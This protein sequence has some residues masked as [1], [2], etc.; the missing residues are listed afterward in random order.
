MAGIRALDVF[1]RKDRE[2]R[3]RQAVRLAQ[4]REVEAQ[5]QRRIETAALAQALADILTQLRVGSEQATFERRRQLL[6][7]LLDRGVVTDEELKM[8]HAIPTTDARTHSRFCQLRTDDLQIEPA[9][10]GPPAQGGD[11]AEGAAAPERERLG[12]T[13]LPG[14]AAYFDQDERALDDRSRLPVP[15][16]GVGL[17]L[18][19]DAAP[20]THPDDDASRVAQLG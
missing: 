4:E 6:K 16:I 15:V 11:G 17:R 18:G 3:E 10:V 14:Q 1:E 20:G 5:G 19:V 9:D 12:P 13:R 7:L 2:R 8:R